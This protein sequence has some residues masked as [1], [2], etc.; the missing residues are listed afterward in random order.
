MNQEHLSLN[1]KTKDGDRGGIR[2]NQFK[3][4]HHVNNIMIIS[5]QQPR[6]TKVLTVTPKTLAHQVKTTV[7][8]PSHSGSCFQLTSVSI[9]DVYIDRNYLPSLPQHP[10]FTSYGIVSTVADFIFHQFYTQPRTKIFTQR[11]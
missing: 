8:C 6:T 4:S 10:L 1:S 11:T 9:S 7:V 5:V 3:F 2:F